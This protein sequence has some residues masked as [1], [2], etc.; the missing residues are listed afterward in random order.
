MRRQR[1]NVFRMR[2]LGAKVVGVATRQP[3]AE[4][5]HQRSHA[6]LG[7]QCARHRIIC[8]ARCSARIPIHMIVRDFHKVIGEEAR[9]QI[10]Q[11]RRPA[12]GLPLCLRR[13][14]IER[15]RALSC[16]SRRRGREDG[17]HRSRRT[18]TR[19]RRARGEARRD[20]RLHG[21]AARSAAGNVHLR[22]ANRRRAD[23]DD[24]LDLGGPRLPG[25]R[26]GARVARGPRPRRIHAP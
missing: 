24:A 13:R 17:G 12:A 26:A 22:A 5:R 8:S 1:L 16:I 10:L 11:A 23:R 18:R 21:R 7:D 14:R 25:D 20:A 4:G 19:T 15:D 2:L 9:A 3:H 6:R